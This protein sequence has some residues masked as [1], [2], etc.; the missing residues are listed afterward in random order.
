MCIGDL[1]EIL[2]HKKKL[3]GCLRNHGS[4]TTFR[5]TLVYH[6]LIDLRYKGP[7]YIWI[8]VHGPNAK[9]GRLDRSISNQAWKALFL[10]AIIWYLP[11]LKPDHRPLILNTYGSSDGRGAFKLKRFENYWKQLDGYH[12]QI[13]NCCNCFLQSPHSIDW[14]ASCFYFLTRMHN[15][16]KKSSLITI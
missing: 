6:R 11:F 7:K 16:G 5:D 13:L 8:H 14:M 15:W 10:K 12:S 2:D 4:I 1:N 9:A 3:G